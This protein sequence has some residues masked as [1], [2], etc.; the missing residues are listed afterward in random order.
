MGRGIGASTDFD[1]VYV[2]YI[3][4]FASLYSYAD[5]QELLSASRLPQNFAIVVRPKAV[6]LA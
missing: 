3:F 4:L 2:A 6:S 1:K 5:R